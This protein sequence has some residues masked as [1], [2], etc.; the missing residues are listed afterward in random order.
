MPETLKEKAA[1]LALTMGCNCDLDNW[2]P[3]PSTGHSWVCRIHEAAT[4]LALAPR[5]SGEEISHDYSK[6]LE[7]LRCGKEG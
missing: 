1:R 4:G 7:R 3:E 2:G 5:M 6:A